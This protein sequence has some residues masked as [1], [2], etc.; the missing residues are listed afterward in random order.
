MRSPKVP[1]MSSEALP[2]GS[3]IGIVGGGQLGRMLAQAAAK[4]GFRASIFCPEPDSPAFH[5]AAFRH[6]AAYDDAAALERFADQADV[7]TFEF[8]NVPARTL[9]II[10]S[11]CA[12]APPRQAL[13]VAQ[14]R[15]EERRFLTSLGLACAP[16]AEVPGAQALPEAWE[17]LT[18]GGAR[19]RLFLKKARF[20]YDG[21]GQTRIESRADV[22]AAMEW[23]GRDAAVLERAVPFRFE[24]SVICVRA[25]A[26]GIAFYD[27]PMNAHRDGILRESQVP[28]PASLDL[29]Y[30]LAER[31]AT[32]L[33]YVGVLAVEMF[34]VE[35]GRGLEPVINEIAPRV[36]NSGHWTPEAC[37]A[38]QFEN[39]IRAVAGW[40]LGSTERHSNARMVNLL[41]PEADEWRALLTENPERS[42]TLYDKGEPRPGRKMGHYVELTPRG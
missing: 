37:A 35:S 27:P 31:I 3:V 40:P 30:G 32:A 20:G 34:A 24:F 17:R 12:V 5:V 2:P 25:R 13:Q 36:H 26:G 22:D 29:A 23:L 19:T 4:L 42:L 10:E 1:S 39:H 33:D 7:V 18:G 8:E 14:D 21:K 9:E 15:L 28:A 38:G 41:G 11:R 16:F 6:C